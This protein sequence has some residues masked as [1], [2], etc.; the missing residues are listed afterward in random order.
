GRSVP[1]AA[2]AALLSVALGPSPQTAASPQAAAPVDCA[3][4]RSFLG[5]A[6][7]LFES[8][9]VDAARSRFEVA[10]ARAR[11]CA[12]GWAEAEAHRGV[13]RTLYRKA[14]YP[15]ARTE[16]EEARRLFA[17]REDA[18]PVL[19]GARHAAPLASIALA[20]GDRPQARA[21]YGEALAAFEGPEARR[22]KA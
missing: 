6:F 12:D 5:E 15:A 7:A 3:A 18:S 21:L 22:D 9:Q 20:T 19:G 8:D 1:F 10:V 2:V 16:L 13:G 14:E 11:E 4:L 17:A